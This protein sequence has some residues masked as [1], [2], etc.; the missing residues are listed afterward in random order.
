MRK[1]IVLIL[2]VVLSAIIVKGQDNVERTFPSKNKPGTRVPECKDD[3]N[4]P[5]IEEWEAFQLGIFP[6]FPPYTKYSN[7]YGLKLGIVSSGGYGR[8]YG[9]E[10]S[11]LTSTTSHIKGTQISVITNICDFIDGLQ[12][13]L[14]NVASLSV[15]GLQIGLVNYS[16]GNGT[17]IGLVNVMPD[18]PIPFLPILNIYS[19]STVKTY[20][21]NKPAD[22]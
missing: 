3:E 11:A 16:A 21:Q 5:P 9:A 6:S 2:F 10:I 8:V 18:A 20:Q 4:I 17:Q 13:S 22:Y 7:V 15:D 1:F 19:V 12:V 14:V